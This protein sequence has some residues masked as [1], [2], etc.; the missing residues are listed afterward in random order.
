[1]KTDNDQFQSDTSLDREI[2]AML[3]VEP[4]RICIYEC[5]NVLPKPRFFPVWTMGWTSL[6]AGSVV[7]AVCRGSRDFKAA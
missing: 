5:E 6:A 7:V 4:S 2:E 3:A 1:M